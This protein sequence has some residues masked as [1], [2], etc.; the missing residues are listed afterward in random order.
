MQVGF[1][2]RGAVRSSG[3]ADLDYYLVPGLV[4]EE[5]G[6]SESF[7]G[8]QQLVELSG[9]GIPFDPP[10]HSL[11]SSHSPPRFEFGG[12]KFYAND[13]LYMVTGSL[14]PGLGPSYDIAL[15]S[16]LSADPNALVALVPDAAEMMLWNP[17]SSATGARLGP[18]Q[19]CQRL[20]ARIRSRI[21]DGDQHRA[22]IMKPLPAEE[23]GQL[24]SIA[25][26]VL[27]VGRGVEALEAVALGVPVVCVGGRGGL[28]C[29]VNRRVSGDVE[30]LCV[31]DDDEGMGEK[32][33]RIG[34][35]AEARGRVVRELEG[36]RELGR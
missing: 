5:M 30:R 11:L 14:P 28:G 29:G 24:L 4:R 19:W 17:P 33:A 34:M 23:R 27:E 15:A 16:L 1:W 12:R 3:L 36:A 21:G 2:A 26:C 6:D 7:G 9:F 18:K 35:D 13:N 32:A 10:Q 20:L 22:F 31:A 25:A 8:G